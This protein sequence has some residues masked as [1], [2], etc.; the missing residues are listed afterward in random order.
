[1]AAV[2]TGKKLGMLKPESWRGRAPMDRWRDKY[3]L[4]IEPDNF[5][6]RFYPHILEALRKSGTPAFTY[7]TP[8]NPE[9]VATY[10]PREKYLVNRAAIAGFFRDPQ[11]PFYDFSDAIPSDYF[12]DNDHM[13]PAGNKL[14]AERIAEKVEPSIR[15]K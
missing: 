12:I 5:N 2:E 7:L 6:G 14:L 13:L 15:S 10:M 9:P 1:M 4:P 3:L 8:Q 11:V